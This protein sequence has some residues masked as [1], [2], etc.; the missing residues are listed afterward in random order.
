[1]S[2]TKKATCAVCTVA[3]LEGDEMAVGN[4]GAYCMP[5]WNCRRFDCMSVDQKATSD[6]IERIAA[7]NARVV[8][9]NADQ[10]SLAVWEAYLGPRCLAI[11]ER[12]LASQGDAP[13]PELIQLQHDLAEIL[14]PTLAVPAAQ[15]THAAS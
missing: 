7:E 2:G 8:F 11:V 3:I 5:C 6:G 12:A 10:V 14:K 9:A 15:L 1:M 4:G 13:E